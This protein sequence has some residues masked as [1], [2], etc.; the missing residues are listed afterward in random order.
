M[1]RLL[2][3]LAL[4]SAIALPAPAQTSEP[5]AT[6]TLQG[7]VTDNYGAGITT[8]FVY[9]QGPNNISQKVPVTDTGDFS[10]QLPPGIYNFFVGSTGFAPFA[11]EIKIS[12]KKPVVMKVKLHVDLDISLDG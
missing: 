4:A 12:L 2:L 5:D 8:A 11:K 9:V 1:F 6:G 7:R 10:V 3:S